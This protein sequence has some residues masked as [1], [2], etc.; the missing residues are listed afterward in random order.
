[1]SRFHGV[2]FDSRRDS[3]RLVTQQ[4]RIRNLLLRQ[5]KHG[6]WMTVNELATA[7]GFKNHESVG[8]QIRYLRKPENGGYRVE[9]RTREGSGL[10]EFQLR[11]AEEVLQLTMEVG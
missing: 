10:A 11:P 5:T 8:R 4:D 7:L 2:E 3:R 9:R 1:M 6:V